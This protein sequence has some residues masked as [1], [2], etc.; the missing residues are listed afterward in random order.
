MSRTGGTTRGAALALLLL[1]VAATLGAPAASARPLAE[2]TKPPKVTKQP[3]SVTV[4]AGQPATFATTASGTPAPTVQ[5]EASSNGGASWSAIE[6]ATS[7]TLTIAST[8]VSENGEQLRAVYRNVA[9]QAISK[10]ATLTVQKAPAIELQPSSTTVEEGQTATFE[11]A[12]SGTPA[13][14]VK[15][16]SSSNGGSTWTAVSGGTSSTLTLAAVTTSLDGREY[17]ATFKNAAGEAV[18]A[19]ATLTV[20][21][22]PAI[23]HQPSSVTVNEGQSAFFEATASGFPPPSEQWESS[24]DGGASWVPIE[25]ATSSALTIAAPTVAEDGRELRA[26]FANAAGSVTSAVATLSVRAVPAITLQPSSVTIVLGESAS[27]EAAATGFPAPSEQWEVSTNLGTTWSAIP[28]ATAQRLNVETPSAAESGREYR[29]VFTNAAGRTVSQVAKLTVATSRFGAVAWG[30]NAYRQLGD[31]FKE[32]SASLPVPVSGL[33]FVTAVAA[34]GRHSLALLADGTVVAWGAGGL[35]QLGDGETSESAVPVHVKGL[36][37]VKAIAAGGSFSLALLGTG[38]VAAWG[39]NEAGQL[40]V[41]ASPEYS[42][43]PLTVGGLTNVKA[44]AA[45][46]GHGLA[47][48]ANGTVMAWGENESGQLG[49]GSLAP[50]STPVAVKHL[51]GV[52]AIAAGGAFSLALLSNGTVMAWGDDERGEL[53][54]VAGEEEGLSKTPVAVE[55]L[56]GATA[57]AAGAD[58]ALALLSGGTVA[59]WGGDSFGQLGDG[60]TAASRP[61][62]VAVGGLSGVT[63]ISAGADDSAAL[64]GSGSV[65]TW[66]TNASGVLGAG[67]TFGFSDVP[68]PVLGVTKVASVSAGRSQM[69]AYGE[70][71]P[72]VTSVGPQFGPSAG[73]TTVTIAGTALADATSVKFGATPAASFTIT[74]SG[75]IEAVA[76]A[77]SGTVD[78]TVTTPSGTSPATASDRFTYQHAPSVTKLAPKSGPVA[79]GTQVTIA[80]TELVGASGVSFGGVPATQ[81][82]VISPSAIVATAPPTVTA[83]VAEVRVTNSAGASAATSKDRFTYTPSIES[84]SPNAG[85]P[86]G[87]TVVTVTGHGFAPG[88]GTTAFRFG[89]AKAKSV[90][91]ASST[92]CEVLAPAQAA[93]TVDVTLAVGKAKSGVNAPADR[94]T[95]G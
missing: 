35:G 84:L 55:H 72:V 12:A 6:G 42:P 67:A 93:G 24:S 43:V 66:G 91:C 87:G 9:G 47:L 95:Y 1:L 10:A 54:N 82:T 86:A 40:G 68:V 11:A 60:A 56:S 29:A 22:A 81:F 27:F 73:G 75:A 41:G 44:I 74:E 3:A 58:H 51:T 71:I 28:G 33:Q 76:P 31:G 7:P 13:P 89:T 36:S 65:M 61:S 14:T 17:R 15:W 5:W 16:E 45:G 70:P 18:T 26:T 50:S 34:G 79:G 37:N 92:S 49:S 8:Q 53:A 85:P 21:K 52:K 69:L 88:A 78:V 46:A 62:P 63:A 83:G 32:L 20:R 4:E 90:T 94:Y 64:L 25:G 30:D 38:Q 57:V 77:G 2:A 39:D 48:L 80:G 23:V 19:P 59:G